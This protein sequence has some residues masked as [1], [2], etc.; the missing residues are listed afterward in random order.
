MLSYCPYISLLL[1]FEVLFAVFDCFSFLIIPNIIQLTS[2]LR[3]IHGMGLAARTIQPTKVL[4]T[5]KNRIRINCAGMIDVISYDQN[6]N[7][8]QL[9]V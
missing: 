9:Q 4:L 8:P 3:T 7:I 2:A 1:L 6:R 5:G